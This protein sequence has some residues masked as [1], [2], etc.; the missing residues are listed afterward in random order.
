MVRGHAPVSWLIGTQGERLEPGE[1]VGASEAQCW[2]AFF[3]PG[4]SQ[5]HA[6]GGAGGAGWCRLATR[7]LQ[8][9]RLDKVA[10]PGVC[11]P[12][13]LGPHARLPS[14]ST[15]PRAAML[16]RRGGEGRGSRPLSGP[17][18]K[19]SPRRS[20]RQPPLTELPTC[21]GRRLLGSPPAEHLELL[22]LPGAKPWALW[23]RDTRRSPSLLLIE[24][25]GR[26]MAGPGICGW[27]P[28]LDDGGGRDLLEAPVSHSAASLLTCKRRGSRSRP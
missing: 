20:G 21:P 14:G 1:A 2:C 22:T 16:T 15:H 7:H 6:A 13:S 24:D 27:K 26:L 8:A 12:P 17:P 10:S 19:P 11:R 4:C 5:G 9:P 23:T 3:R 25:L 18:W 28:S